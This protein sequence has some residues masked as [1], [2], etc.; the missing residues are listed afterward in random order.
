M[1]LKISGKRALVTGSSSGI[2]A[3]TAETLAA[4][5][6]KVV[7]HGRDAAR[8][9]AVADR[10]KAAGGEAVVALGDLVTDEAADSVAEAAIAAWGGIDILVNN[11]GGPSN[12]ALNWDNIESEDWARTFNLNTISTVRMIKRCVPGM[13]ANGWGRIIQMSSMAAMRGGP[14]IPDYNAVKASLN[15]M[16]VSLAKALADTGITVNTV[17]PGLI[18][19]PVLENYFKSL[20]DNA[21]KTW[22]EI[23]PTLSKAYNGLVKRLGRPQ[24]IADA[25][26]FLCS[27][28]A[29]HITGTNLRIDGGMTGFMN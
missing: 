2:G 21:G 16:S 4:E 1:D 14:T 18:V 9:Q 15:T 17:S 5:G 26:T 19:T 6:V 23:E 11:A 3:A 22:D 25:I 13:K 7:V 8:A 12:P 29:D 24:D 28:R 20:P 27:N 10:I